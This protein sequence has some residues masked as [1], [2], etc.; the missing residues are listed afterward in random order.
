[1]VSYGLGMSATPT[2]KPQV[3]APDTFDGKPND[4]K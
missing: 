4:L 3:P 2:V 1:M